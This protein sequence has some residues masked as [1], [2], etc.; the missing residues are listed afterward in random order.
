MMKSRPYEWITFLFY[1]YVIELAIRVAILFVCLLL[2]LLLLLLFSI[3]LEGGK[4]IP[5]KKQYHSYQIRT[6]LA[7]PKTM[8]I[9]RGGT[10]LSEGLTG[11]AEKTKEQTIKQ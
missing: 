11:L 2:L 5:E 9:L 6:D 7:P 4:V 10:H 8:N 1:V 3:F